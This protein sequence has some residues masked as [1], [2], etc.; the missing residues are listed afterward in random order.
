MLYSVVLFQ[1]GAYPLCSSSFSISHAFV[2]L[3]LQAATLRQSVEDEIILRSA[4]TL[5]ADSPVHTTIAFMLSAPLNES[6]NEW[7]CHK[8]LHALI[9][10]FKQC[11]DFGELLQQWN[12]WLKQSDTVLSWGNL[13]G[14]PM[15]LDVNES[16]RVSSC[17]YFWCLDAVFTAFKRRVKCDAQQSEVVFVKSSSMLAV[18]TN[19]E[20]MQPRI[21]ECAVCLTGALFHKMSLFY[22]K[23]GDD[24]LCMLI[25]KVTVS[26]AELN[27]DDQSIYLLAYDKGFLRYP[28]NEMISF[29]IEVRRLCF[30]FESMF[31]VTLFYRLWNLLLRVRY[32]NIFVR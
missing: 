29:S 30:S 2:W 26:L 3:G 19:V 12:E 14:N 4:R 15:P 17:V 1:I 10:I 24:E 7:L 21:R 5:S 28:T 16:L 11:S 27:A 6:F 13:F 32:P 23:L 31:C 22:C 18:D 20:R 25:D 9:R 8:A